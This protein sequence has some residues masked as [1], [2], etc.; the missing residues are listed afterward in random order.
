MIFILIITHVQAITT[1]KILFKKWLKVIIPIRPL[2]IP[3]LQH[4]MP[5]K[6]KP[7][8]KNLSISNVSQAERPKENPSLNHLLS[9]PSSQLLHVQF[10]EETSKSYENQAASTPS[11]DLLMRIF[12]PS[13]I[14]KTVALM[15]IMYIKL[16][17]LNLQKAKKMQKMEL[18]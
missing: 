2:L 11:I 4:P 16:W 10:Q 17:P 8:S 14:P 6:S 1:L 7:N 15:K 5:L 12:I 18:T 9:K 13:I 3:S